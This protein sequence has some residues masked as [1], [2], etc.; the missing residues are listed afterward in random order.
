MGGFLLEAPGLEQP[1]PL[2]AEQLFYLIKCKYVEYP[3]V[4][5][6]ELDDRDKSDG[7]SR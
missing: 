4:T 2:D 7:L 3:S 1:I 6:Q 5:K